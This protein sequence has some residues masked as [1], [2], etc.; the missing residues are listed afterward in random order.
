MGRHRLASEARA[1]RRPKIV[2]Q[3]I[4]NKPSRPK[5]APPSVGSAGVKPPT[6]STQPH[7][8]STPARLARVWAIALTSTSTLC[9]PGMPKRE[10]KMKN[11]TPVTPIDCA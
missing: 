7:A 4:E 9:A 3:A 2:T 11:G 10:A 8:T 6:S 5:T 1:A